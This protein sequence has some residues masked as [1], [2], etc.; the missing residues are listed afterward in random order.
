VIRNL[1]FKNFAWEGKNISA[2]MY[3][4]G[5]FVVTFTDHIERV[6]QNNETPITLYKFFLVAVKEFLEHSEPKLT[7]YNGTK[8]IH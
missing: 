4:D 6:K 8:Q 1:E 7:Q 5:N 3:L 2:D